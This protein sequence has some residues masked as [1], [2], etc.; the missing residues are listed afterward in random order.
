MRTTRTTG[1][2]GNKNNRSARAIKA[3][4]PKKPITPSSFN[5]KLTLRELLTMISSTAG[6]SIPTA[7]G[8]R[9]SGD[10]IAMYAVPNFSIS[11]YPS[12]F[13]LAVSY[14]RTTVVR[15][16]ECTDYSYDTLHEALAN[17]KKSATPSHIGFEVFLDAAWPVRVTMTAEDQLER[18]NNG[19]AWSRICLHP[20]VAAD[21]KEYNRSVHGQSIEDMAF[22]KMEKE[23]MLERLTDKQREAYALYYDEGYTMEEIGGMLGIS[24]DA[25]KDRLHSAVQKT[26][27][28]IAENQ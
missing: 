16:D 8:L 17:C 25:V 28:Y 26:R 7:K 13:A 2:T 5:D 9:T 20:D 22:A 21:V 4:A 14:K 15:V 6:V 11:V 10:P 19:A 1:T 12:G 18:N 3:T 27:K 23:E 24:R